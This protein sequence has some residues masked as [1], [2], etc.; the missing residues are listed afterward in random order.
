MKWDFGNLGKTKATSAQP[1]GCDAHV[2]VWCSVTHAQY[3]LLRARVTCI[4]GTRSRKPFLVNII[5]NS[6]VDIKS[7]R[8]RDTSLNYTWSRKRL[9][10]HVVSQT[11]PDLR[12]SCRNKGTTHFKFIS[13]RRC[14]GRWNKNGMWMKWKWNEVEMATLKNPNG[15]TCNRVQHSKIKSKTPR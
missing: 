12:V 2:R 4:D 9:S 3:N 10:R 6:L 1:S 11:P 14:R 8:A 15:S 7:L 13:V 5:A